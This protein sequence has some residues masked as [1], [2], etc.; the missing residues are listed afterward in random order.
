MSPRRAVVRRFELPLHQPLAT[1]HG[2]I[3]R[4]EGYLVELTDDDGQ[5]GYGEATPLPG[6]GTEDRATCR[7]ALVAAIESFV[8]GQPIEQASLEG[9]DASPCATF[10]MTTAMEDLEARR[11]GV[12]LAVRL[13]RDLDPPATSIASQA[14]VGGETAGDVRE[15]SQRAIELGFRVF[16]LKL[17]V[18]PD[19]REL[20]TDIERVEALREAVGPDARIRLDANEAWALKEAD[21][22]LRALARF[23]IDYVEQPVAAGDLAGLK[24]LSLNGAIPV[25]ADEAL[26]GAG[27]TTCLEQ[28]AAKILIVKPAALGGLGRAQALAIRCRDEGLRLVWSTMIDGAVGRGAAFALAAAFDDPEEVHGLGTARLLALDLG[29]ETSGFEGGRFA[30][31]AECGLG[32]VPELESASSDVFEV[33]S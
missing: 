13:A 17:A 25:A 5:R 27:L 22:A 2:P 6:F 12:P 32:F 10:A 20:A 29:E 15:S 8:L 24:S 21:Q 26:L 4:R 9:V 1:A 33:S 16:K 31:R 7:T 28:R 3:E 19:A 11:E 23:D 30:L 18:S 14:L